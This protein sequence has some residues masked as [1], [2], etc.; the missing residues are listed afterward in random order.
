MPTPNRTARQAILELA[1]RVRERRT[2]LD[3]TQQDVAYSAGVTESYL[4]GLERAKPKRLELAGILAV[5]EAL[6][7]EGADL[8]RGLKADPLP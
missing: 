6:D 5:A 1:V 2:A 8:I 7:M 3:L 4:S